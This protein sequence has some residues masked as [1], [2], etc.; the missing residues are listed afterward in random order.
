MVLCSACVITFCLPACL[1]LSDVV[2]GGALQLKFVRLTSLRN[3]SRPVRSTTRKQ[4][5]GA[6][7]LKFCGL[8]FFSSSHDGCQIFCHNKTRCGEVIVPAP[9][10]FNFTECWDDPAGEIVELKQEIG[11]PDRSKKKEAVK[12]VI[13]GAVAGGTWPGASWPSRGA[14]VALPQP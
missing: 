14:V 4:A 7:D 12:K 5:A 2:G 8:S 9:P 11:V 1:P 10:R 13:A 3:S 6:V